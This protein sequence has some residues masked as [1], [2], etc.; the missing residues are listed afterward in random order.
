MSFGVL[1][2]N[3]YYVAAVAFV[4]IRTVGADFDPLDIGNAAS[5]WGRLVASSVEKKWIRDHD[6]HQNDWTH[7]V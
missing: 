3:F 6:S 4:L 7:V 1:L 2:N 5:W